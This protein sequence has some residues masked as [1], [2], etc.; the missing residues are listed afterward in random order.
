[1]GHLHFIL[2]G[3][4]ITYGLN[5]QTIT[6]QGLSYKI[7][8][9]PHTQKEWL[10]RNL[11]AQKVC[12]SKFDK[13]CFGDYY[14]WGRGTDGHEK[15]NS[16]VIRK[17]QNNKFTGSEFIS[18]KSNQNFDWRQFRNDQLWSI[19][20]ICPKGFKVPSIDE[21]RAEFNNNA[22]GFLNIPLA[23][24]KTFCNG[25]LVKQKLQ[26]S[27]WS[28]TSYEADAYYIEL[29]NHQTDISTSSRADAFSVRCIRQ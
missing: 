28:S 5:A 29:R 20:N 22:Y 16:K 11:G 4:F 27:L 1:M 2:I 17:S 26:A 8:K 15:Y 18:V 12:T 23:G 9:S 19:D 10:D 24:Y 6:F 14:Q 13:A 3:L 7:I 21:L 25:K